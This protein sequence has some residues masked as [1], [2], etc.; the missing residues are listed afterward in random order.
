MTT[1]G[2]T[3]FAPSIADLA[4]N[5]WSR[6]QIKPAALTQDHCLQL[7]LEGNLLQAEWANDGILLWK[8]TLQQQ[9]LT[10]GTGTYSIPSSVVMITEAYISVDSPALNRFI[11]PFS[12]T[13]YASLSYPT[14]QGFPTSYWFDRILSPTITLWPI[15]D[16][17]ATYTLNF[18][19]YSQI[20]D[21][22]FAGGNQ[23][24]VPYLALDAFAA[25]L[26]YR[27]ARHFAPSLEAIR[28]ADYLDAW[29][30][31]SK[32]YTENVPL[33]VSPALDNYFRP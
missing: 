27:L 10:Q 2:T 1:S 25:G 30:K 32:Q 3:A 33:Y 19:S 13:D 8:E 7:R 31:F 11:T 20:Q 14:Q 26:A 29:G 28:K 15:P 23:P 21:A 5:A 9:A 16:G 18:W 4:L 24:D 17:N 22:T 12:R 6:I